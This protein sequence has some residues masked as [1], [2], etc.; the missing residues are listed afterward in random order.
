MIPEIGIMIGFF[1]LARLIPSRWGFVSSAF[2]TMAFAVAA[3]V[4]ADL[5]VKGFSDTTFASLLSGPSEPE[6]SAIREGPVEPEEESFSSFSGSRADGG[7]VS[8]DLGYGI[9]LAKGSSLHREWIAVHDSA[10]P[11]D[12]EGSPGIR[13]IYTNNYR[14]RADFTLVTRAAVRAFEVRFLTFDVWGNHVRNLRFEE[15]TDV[16]ANASRKFQGTWSLHSESDA[17]RHYASIAYVSR[18]RLEDGRVLVANNEPVL[19][20]ARKFSS[21]FTAEDLD[22]SPSPK[23]ASPSAEGSPG[24]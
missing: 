10:F 2:R 19:V 18:V 22:P 16:P 14:Y 11:A 21:K 4:V 17:K 13:T 1:I 8:I 9:V 20:E 3:V 12:L 7:S 15:V 6:I 24:T 23:E 5:S